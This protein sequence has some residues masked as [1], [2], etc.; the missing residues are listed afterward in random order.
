MEACNVRLILISV[1]ALPFALP[2][3]S[4]DPIKV[5][6]AVSTM[7]TC[8]NNFLVNLYFFVSLHLYIFLWGYSVFQ[9]KC[10][11]SKEEKTSSIL[12]LNQSG[13]YVMQ[14]TCVCVFRLHTLKPQWFNEFTNHWHPQRYQEHCS[15]WHFMIRG[16]KL[17][18]TTYHN[19][20]RRYLRI[21]EHVPTLMWK[22][23]S[24]EKGGKDGH[25]LSLRIKEI[26]LTF[27]R[28]ELS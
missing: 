4:M 8:T 24:C 5:C 22:I 20:N 7:E 9:S 2:L 23:L 10:V 26:W 12:E 19:V 6:T 15:A 28:C 18:K 25:L 17:V 16:S 14:N 11:I 27:H 21:R 13:C 1:H 3:S